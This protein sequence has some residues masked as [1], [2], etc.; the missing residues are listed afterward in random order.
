LD[1]RERNAVNQEQKE[2]VPIQ[3]LEQTSRLQRNLPIF[4]IFLPEQPIT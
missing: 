3:E 1:A 4:R 2:N